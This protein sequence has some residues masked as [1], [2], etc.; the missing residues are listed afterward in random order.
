MLTTNPPESI[1]AF[2]FLIRPCKKNKKKRCYLF[3]PNTTGTSKPIHLPPFRNL[4][5]RLRQWNAQSAPPNLDL[6]TLANEFH[7]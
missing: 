6:T 2:Y 1:L 4:I 5:T 3:I 7:V